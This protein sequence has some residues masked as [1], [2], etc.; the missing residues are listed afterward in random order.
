VRT[1]APALATALVIVASAAAG[2]SP[3][4]HHRVLVPATSLGDVRLGEP[5][6]AVRAHLGTTYRVCAHCR[7]TTWYFDAVGVSFRRARVSAVFTLGSP[8]GWRTREGLRLG[9]GI[10]RVRELYGPVRSTLCIGYMA[11]SMRRAR[12]VTSIYATGESV[13][14]FALTRPGEPVCQ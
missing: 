10:G 8:P 14:G 7:E 13:Y 5:E 4:P 12:A 11:L 2:D 6:R 1:I 9:A 3:L